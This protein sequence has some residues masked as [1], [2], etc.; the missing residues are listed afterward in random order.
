MGSSATALPE[1]TGAASGRQAALTAAVQALR[2]GKIESAE[3]QIDAVLARWPGYDEAKHFL[4]VLRHEQGR[5]DDALALIGAVVLAQPGHGGAW[6]NLGNVLLSV[7][8]ADDARGAYQRATEA[9]DGQ[10]QA[11]A[12]LANM[13]RILRHQ[14]RWAEAEASCRQAL[15]LCPDFAEAWFNLSLVLMNSGRINEGLLANSRAIALWPQHLQARDQVIRAL[16]LLG[17]YARAAQLYR[18]WL[19]E[20]P[21]NP[22]VQ[23]QLAACL[24][25]MG[26]GNQAAVPERAS[27]A[28]VTQV[29]DAFAASFDAKL[30]ALDY[31]AP[32]LVVQALVDAVGPAQGTLD[33]VDAGC[34]T[35][36]CGPL[37][38]PLARHLAGCDLSEGMLRRAVPRRCYDVLHQAEL[39]HYLNTQ[40]GRFDAVVSADTLCYFGDLHAPLAAA[41]HALRPGGWVVFT[42]E[43]LGDDDT[44][45]SAAAG[46]GHRLQANGRYA[47]SRT[48][49][50][51]AAAAAG[52][53]VDRIEPQGL[54]LEAGRPVAG[55]L[56]VAHPL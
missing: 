8:R 46:A 26:Q 21:D 7:G 56:V 42:V 6:N 19:A 43:A 14:G 3:A 44:P 23:H 39:M 40:P 2:E 48:H 22:V 29:F 45:E 50:H 41:A 53:G 30:E 27:D 15:E 31:R 47:H 36:L 24:G 37:L 35:G 4:G 28:Y 38:R 12:P 54:R 17:E 5:S 49:V 18:D 55:W 16:L 13:S 32:G 10:P 25:A 33:I 11:A 1:G 20:E 9:A 52:L 34:G 51:A